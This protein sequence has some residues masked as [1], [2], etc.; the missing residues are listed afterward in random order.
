MV[1]SLLSVFVLLQV[2]SP[3]VSVFFC[4]KSST[5]Q[6]Q[7]IFSD[8]DNTVK[9][10]GPAEEAASVEQQIRAEFISPIAHDRLELDLPGELCNYT[11]YDWLCL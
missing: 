6:V 7:V 8:P 11:S 10:K 1:P 2:S 3:L 4:F 5:G 9:I